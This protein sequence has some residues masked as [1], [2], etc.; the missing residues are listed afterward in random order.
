MRKIYPPNLVANDAARA[1]RDVIAN[2]LA[3]DAKM[4]VSALISASARTKAM[5][6][7]DDM[8]DIW[9]CL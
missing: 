3:S 4:P 5:V 6:A 8:D 1:R 9:V 2:V 7:R